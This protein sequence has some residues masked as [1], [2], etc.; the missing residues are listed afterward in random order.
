MCPICGP[1]VFTCVPHVLFQFHTFT[2]MW[3]KMSTCVTHVRSGKHM[4]IS[5]VPHA[6]HIIPH[7]TT[8]EAHVDSYLLALR[9]HVKRT[10]EIGTTHK[11]HMWISCDFSVG[12]ST[13]QETTASC[14]TQSQVNDLQAYRSLTECINRLSS[15]LG[16]IGLWTASRWS[17]G[18]QSAICV[19]TQ[20]GSGRINRHLVT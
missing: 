12:G 4:W 1:H 5:C 13:R 9:S 11:I 7:V 16:P 18:R 10:C 17:R 2:H 14:A 15:S 19:N 20:T 3:K 6:T 8:C